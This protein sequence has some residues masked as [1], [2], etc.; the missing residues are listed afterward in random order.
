MGICWASGM[1]GRWAGPFGNRRYVRIWTSGGDTF[2]RFTK[3][4]TGLPLHFTDS[5]HF[6][7]HPATNE[8]PG[9]IHANFHMVSPVPP[10][11]RTKGY[12]VMSLVAS[13]VQPS[14]P[15]TGPQCMKSGSFL[16]GGLNR[17]CSGVGNMVRL[18]AKLW[19]GMVRPFCFIPLSP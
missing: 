7:F 9:S 1:L 11:A 3:S 6:S 14:L 8:G 16:L 10:L 19:D 12:R 2:P 18:A 17:M 13:R 4:A 5:G 15:V